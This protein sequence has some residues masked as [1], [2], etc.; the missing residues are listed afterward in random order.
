[1]P[2]ACANTCSCYATARQLQ[3]ERCH[4]VADASAQRPA[5]PK[6]DSCHAPARTRAGD[7]QWRLGELR[8]ARGD[9]HYCSVARKFWMG[10]AP[11]ASDPEPG[12]G[13]ARRA[14]PHRLHRKNGRADEVPWSGGSS[15]LTLMLDRSSFGCNARHVQQRSGPP[16]RLFAAAVV[17]RGGLGVLDVWESVPGASIVDVAGWQRPVVKRE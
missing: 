5:A 12:A 17:A 9:D 1:M 3:A 15:L 4:G 13:S 16:L 2:T 11:R 7:G 8:P 14:S 10:Q 6:Q